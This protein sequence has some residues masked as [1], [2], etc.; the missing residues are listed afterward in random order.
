MS[1]VKALIGGLIG[2]V[3]AIVV[4]M[5]LRD[6]DM[7]GY[8]W[9]PLVTGLLT[10]LGARLLTGGAGRSL[11]TGIVA[12][13]VAMVA[14]LAGDD[15][16]QLVKNSS[17]DLGPIA[18]EDLI[19]TADMPKAEPAGDEKAMDDSTEDGSED[20]DA[21]ESDG[22]AAVDAAR[23]RARSAEADARAGIISGNDMMGNMPPAKRPKTLKDFLP[24][25]FSG[26]GV[27]IAY[28]LGRGTPPRR[29]ES[30]EE[31]VREEAASAA[32]ADQQ[33]NS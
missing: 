11:L 15:L 32:D 3:I 9:F 27:L 22:D 16:L 20:S 7:R 23:E 13:L 8:E 6:G 21:G 24:Y 29:V 10:G 33:A 28:Q 4:L 1:I 5:V 31:H 18:Q 17:S 2:A 26:L 19:Q 12:A 30:H 14:I 25:I